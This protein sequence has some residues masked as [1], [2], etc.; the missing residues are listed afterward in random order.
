MNSSPIGEGSRE[1]YH[2]YIG[3]L[4]KLGSNNGS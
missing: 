4:C 2:G 3:V 1:V